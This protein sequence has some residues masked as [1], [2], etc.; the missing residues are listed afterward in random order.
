MGELEP[1][2]VSPNEDAAG[3]GLSVRVSRFV[4]GF[5]GLK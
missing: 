1:L 4:L 3:P 2:G 5:D